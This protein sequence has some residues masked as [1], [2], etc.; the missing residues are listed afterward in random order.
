VAANLA[1]PLT[2]SIEPLDPESRCRVE[3]LADEVG[4]ARPRLADPCA[5]LAPVDLVRLH[6]A[7]ALALTPQLLL[8]EHPTKDVAD[9]AARAEIG[10]TLSRISEAR[11]V[12]W[13]AFAD[14]PVFA[15][16]S[17]GQRWRVDLGTG[18]LARQR[19]WRS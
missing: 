8:L 11:Q 2:V 6:L 13:L 16:Q 19:W 14:D 12:G 10:R 9:D 17:A 3:A 1:L 18:A 4:L 15:K 5:S 7:R